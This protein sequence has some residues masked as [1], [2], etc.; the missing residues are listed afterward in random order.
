MW[1]VF[2]KLFYVLL[3]AG[4]VPLSLSWQRP[5]LRWAAILYDALLLLA[6]FIDSRVSSLPASVTVEREFGGRFS[7]GAETEV[8]LRVV[9]NSARAVVLVLKDEY[10]PEMKLRGERGGRLRVEPHTAATLSYDLTP[11]R[12]GRFEFGRTVVRYLSRFGLVWNQGAA[13]GNTPVKVY[14][15]MRRAREA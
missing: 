4:L 2:S 11:P 15:N 1:F 3:A 8:R 6:A 10:P 5:A 14:P 9:N 12:R 13:G 7:V